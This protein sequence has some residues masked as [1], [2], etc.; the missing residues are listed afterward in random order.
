MECRGASGSSH[1]STS[2]QAQSRLQLSPKNR[3]SIGFDTADL[4]DR[5]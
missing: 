5:A 1:G 2:P 4:G 3:F